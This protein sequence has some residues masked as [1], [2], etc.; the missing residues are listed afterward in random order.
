MKK[1]YE[2]DL[3]WKQ[4][5]ANEIAEFRRDNTEGTGRVVKVQFNDA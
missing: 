3:A 5:F 4:K 1:D 2:K